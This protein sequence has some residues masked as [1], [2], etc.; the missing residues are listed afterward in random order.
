MLLD[1]HSGDRRLSQE[2]LDA[3]AAWLDSAGHAHVLIVLEA[4]VIEK[5]GVAVYTDY[6]GQVYTSALEVCNVFLDSVKT[7]AWYAQL[8]NGLLGP[9]LAKRIADAQ[10]NISHPIAKRGLILLSDGLE[11]YLPP[12]FQCL[13]EVVARWV[14]FTLAH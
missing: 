2:S 13:K 11:A 10:S 5:G 7:N 4:S 14:C 9:R 12:R 1:A 3:A 8:A 6:D